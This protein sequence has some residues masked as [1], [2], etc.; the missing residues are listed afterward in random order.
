MFTEMGTN[1]ATFKTSEGLSP[2]YLPICNLAPDLSK[3]P[4]R[5]Q[6]VMEIKGTDAPGHPRVE[7]PQVKVSLS[8]SGREKGG[9]EPSFPG[10]LGEVRSPR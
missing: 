5:P 10:R 7:T 6:T 3:M 2:E 4:S 1:L 8:R 9:Q